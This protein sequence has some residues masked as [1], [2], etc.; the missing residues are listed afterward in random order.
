[1]SDA[2]NKQFRASYGLDAAGEKLINVALADRTVMSDGINVEYMIQENTIQAYSETRAYPKGFAVM[3][4]DR[5]W[6][7]IVDIAKPSGV[8]NEAKWEPLR[9]DPKWILVNSGVKILQSGQ[10]ISVDTSQGNPIEFT[11]PSD[12]I[13]GDTIVVKDIGGRPGFTDVVVKAGVQSIV[14]FQARVREVKMT[15]PYSQFVFVYNNRLW[16]LHNTVQPDNAITA[17][18]SNIADIQAGQTVIRQYNTLAPITMRLPK[19]ANN[20]DIIHFV[21]MDKPSE[22]YYHLIVNTFDANTSVEV[23]GQTTFELKR[24]FSGYFIFNSTTKTWA[25]YDADLS[26]RLRTVGADTLLFPGETVSV[27]GTNNTTIQT[28]TLTLPQGVSPGDQITVALNYMRKGQTVKIVPS[29]T[30]KILTDM[31]MMQFPKRSSYPPAGNWVNT[32]EL[33]FNG[34][35]TYPPIIT[36]AYIP[37]GPIRQWMVVQNVPQLERVDPTDDSTRAR[38]GVIALATQAQANL[39][40]ENI[41]AASKEVAITPETLANRTATETRRGIAEI[42]TTAEVNQVSTASYL[43]DVIVTPKKLNERVATETMRGLAEIATQAETNAGTD[44]VTIITPKKLEARRATPTMAGIAKLVNVGGLPVAPGVGVT[45]DNEGTGIFAHSNFTDIVTPKTLREMHATELSA[46]IVFLATENETI[47][48]SVSTAAY[49]LAVTP[50]QLHKKTA[51]E[52]RIGFSEIATQAETNAGTDDFRFITPKKLAGRGSTET[53]TGVARIATQSEFDSGILD[54]VIST[55]LKIK[56]YFN[57]ASRTSVNSDSGLVET[58]TLWNHYNL[59]ILEASITQRGTLK[60][61]DQTLTNTGV[62]DTTAVTPKTLHNKKSTQTTEGIIRTATNAEA[63][64]GTSTIL[65]ITPATLKHIVQNEVTWEATTTRRGMVKLTEGALT[66]VGNGTVG[67]TAALDTYLKT[68]YAISPYEL[69][70]TLANYLPLKAKAVDSELLDGLDSIQFIRRDIDQ[71]VNGALTLT[72]PLTANSTAWIK[73]TV[74]LGPKTTLV[75]A[76]PIA[77]AKAFVSPTANFAFVGEKNGTSNK[78]AIGYKYLTANSNLIDINSIDILS[79]GD[80][81]LY[82]NVDI[83]KNATVGTSLTVTANTYS[84]KYYVAGSLLAQESGGKNVIGSSERILRLGSTD[85]GNIEAADS[86]ASYRVLTEKNFVEITDRNFVNQ[87]GDTMTGRLTVNAPSSSTFTGVTATNINQNPTAASIGTWTVEI[88]DSA[89][90]NQLNGYL[91][92]IYVNHPD[93]GLPILDHYDEVKS[94]GTLSQFGTDLKTSYQIWVPKPTV[95]TQDHTANTMW[96]RH[97]NV[98]KNAWDGFARVYTSNQP[99]TAAD[100]G[101]MSNDGSMFNNF[102]V[103]DWIQIGN[104]RIYADQASRTVKFDWID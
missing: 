73:D 89:I 10:Y 68:G 88:T 62:D 75:D 24:S 19:N 70:K 66:F 56:T 81:D 65:A 79:N 30:D 8:F 72:Q 52:G 84:N 98:A 103:R 91:V 94:G 39:N 60:L 85:A 47:A 95:T 58:G 86:S 1:M 29:G 20:G 36:F 102:R 87:A 44:D 80:V 55:P 27:V 96:I 16:Q 7:S 57:S 42:A 71:T 54:N 97:F 83:A 93:T 100:I 78:F 45:R 82:G 48:G 51:T 50:D 67:S 9:V 74:S 21:G 41:T 77:Y 40:H 2:I 15:I 31:N 25:L 18:T 63:T 22:P 90:Y 12:A 46:G 35:A 33:S 11:L 3:H 4:N 28:I 69:N 92:P 32:T 6:V 64:T 53:M 104:M 38:L 23:Q 49:P 76:T 99:P 101:A 37:M 14:N 17:N 61:S 34:N 43:D 26:D 59:N 13:D 5:M